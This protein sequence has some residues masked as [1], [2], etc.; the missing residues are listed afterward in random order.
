M[1]SPMGTDYYAY[2]R[3]ALHPHSPF[4]PTAHRYRLASAV[5]PLAAASVF[6]TRELVWQ[7]VTS[8]LGVFLFCRPIIIRLRTRYPRLTMTY[9]INRYVCNLCRHAAVADYLSAF[10]SIAYHRILN[11]HWLSSARARGGRA[12]F[13]L[14]HGYNTSPRPPLWF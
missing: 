10:Y 6:L 8:V 13:L 1:S 7:V 11:W 4:H 3:S 14:R 2:Y 5:V 12:Q 9:I